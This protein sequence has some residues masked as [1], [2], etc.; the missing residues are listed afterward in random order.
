MNRTHC[1]PTPNGPVT[2]EAVEVEPEGDEEQ[3]PDNRP[4]STWRIS[5]ATTNWRGQERTERITLQRGNV[6]CNPTTVGQVPESACTYLVSDAGAV[7]RLGA[8]VGRVPPGTYTH[9]AGGNPLWG[10]PP[11]G[12]REQIHISRISYR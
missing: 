4:A 7:F 3:A 12:E 11:F 2:Y 5:E 6:D 8:G 10:P 9:R 1:I